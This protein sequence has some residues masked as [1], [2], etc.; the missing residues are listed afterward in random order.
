M[1]RKIERTKKNILLRKPSIIIAS[2]LAIV[3]IYISVDAF[4][5]SR[6]QQVDKRS[7][8]INQVQQGAFVDSINVRGLIT[9]K[10]TVYLDAVSGGRVEEIYIEHGAIVKEGQP[11]LKLSNSALQLDVISREAQISEQLNFLRNTQMTA[12]TNRLA[13]KRELLDNDKEIAQL[14]RELKASNEL[15]KRNL[16]A[17]DDVEKLEID[18]NY[19]IERKKINIQRQEQEEKIREV[20]IKQLEESA[21]TLQ[22]NLKFARKNLENLLVTAPVDGY[23]SDLDV[24]LGESKSAGERLGQIDIPNEYKV[25]ASIDEFYLNLLSIDM[26]VS[27][28]L[29]GEKIE[30]KINKIDSRVNS[31]R[32]TI[33]VYIPQAAVNNTA[34]KR[35]QSV[36]LDVF[37]SAGTEN[38]LLV[39]RGAFV[40]ETGGNWIFVVKGNT[41]TKRAIKLG[42]KNQ[43]YYM[44][45]DGLSDGDQI[46]TS[47]YD[48]FSNAESLIL[49]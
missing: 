29:N 4:S 41:A 15:F 21:I 12:E 23:L 36:D 44:V 32:F 14:K 27:I 31:G 24:D 38:A 19:Y 10:T 22:S 28:E 2:A 39:K 45:E 35:G 5:S 17:K 11:L 30:A 40:N 13:L 26:P 18:L 33:E 43:D 20:Q 9:P 16:I 46:I 1:D 49:K 8:L 7:I 6:S 47:S 34:L 42:R 25:L 37:L 3:L 48:L